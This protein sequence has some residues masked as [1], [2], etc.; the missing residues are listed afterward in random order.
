MSTRDTV[1]VVDD[2]ASVRRGL[3]RLLQAAGYTVVTC[4]TPEALLALMPFTRPACVLLD[5]RMPTMTGLELQG[6][7]CDAGR[8][9]PIIMISG[10]ADAATTQ[11]ALSAGAV[12]VLPKPVELDALVHAVELGFAKQRLN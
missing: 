5:V 10:H 11:R 2:D 9:P 1:Y 4:D 3:G 6:V 8:Q 12:A 7:L